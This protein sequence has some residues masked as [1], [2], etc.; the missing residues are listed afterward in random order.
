V[1]VIDIW[2]NIAVRYRFYDASGNPV[3]LTVPDTGGTFNAIFAH[4]DYILFNAGHAD[5]SILG[6]QEYRV[7]FNIAE[8]QNFIELLMPDEIDL[9]GTNLSFAGWIDDAGT[10]Y[11]Y[12]RITGALLLNGELMTFFGI[13]SITTPFELTAVWE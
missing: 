8:P 11:E 4:Q 3:T 10:F 13:H 6:Y 5:A 1:Y 2:D 12:N 7:Y 9:F